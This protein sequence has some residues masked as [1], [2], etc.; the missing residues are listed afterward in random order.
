MFNLDQAI[1]EWRRQMLAAGI[2]APVPL[3]E[4]E[5]HLHEEMEQQMRSGLNAQ[6]AF[7]VATQ[8][9]GRSDVLKTEFAKTGDFLGWFGD[10]RSTR[11]NRLLGALWLA[12]CLW[13]LIYIASSPAV[14][15]IILYFPH[16]W[17]FFA[18]FFTTLCSAG[19][20][21]SIFLFRG[22]KLGQH[23]IRIMAILGFL[24]GVLECVTQDGSFSGIPKY[25]FGILSIFSL[26]TLW[27][28]RSPAETSSNRVAE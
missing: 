28:L 11:I 19:F 5:S 7:E 22:A 26:V 18:V 13:F 8:R 23:S 10:S 6:Q 2:K 24:L 25:W 27:L 20:F 9:I 14:G 1:A 16:F 12:Q 4:L 15:A 17:S 21:G 3:D